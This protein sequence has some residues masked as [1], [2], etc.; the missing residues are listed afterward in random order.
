MITVFAANAQMNSLAMGAKK[1]DGTV[2][3]RDTVTNTDTTYLTATITGSYDLIFKTTVTK[4]SGTV[5]GSMLL[6]GSVDNSIWFTLANSTSN[7]ASGQMSDT[8]TVTNATA[9]YHWRLDNHKWQY[10]RVRYISS[11]TQTSYPSGTVYYRK[12]Q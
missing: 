8:A 2:V 3:T 11:G 9:S 5:G 12:N 7:I 6:Q 4:I 10:Y 1:A